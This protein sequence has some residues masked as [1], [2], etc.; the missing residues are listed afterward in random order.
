MAPHTRRSPPSPV[1]RPSPRSRC[2]GRPPA[3]EAS[4]SRSRR[5]GSP[6]AC[7][8]PDTRGSR[9]GRR[10]PH[11][12]REA[13]GTAAGR[14]VGLD[15]VGPLELDGRRHGVDPGQVLD[16]RVALEPSRQLGAPVAGDPGDHHTAPGRHL[17][18]GFRLRPCPDGGL[19]ASSRRSRASSRPVTS[20]LA[21]CPRR[22]SSSRAPWPRR[23]ELVPRLRPRRA[24]SSSSWVARSPRSAAEPARARLPACDRVPS[25]AARSASATPFSL[26]GPAPSALCWPGSG[27][28]TR[29]RRAAPASGTQAAAEAPPARR[30]DRRGDPRPT[31]ACWTASAGA[32]RAA[33]A[34]RPPGC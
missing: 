12:F 16:R 34:R 10:C 21:S 31:R 13:A 2:A 7:P 1:P 32:A 9:S 4:R 25:I 15:E 8:A 5:G 20:S 27:T 6:R 29:S 11:R 19:E 24:T 26:A 30:P 18:L 33:R 14:D 28:E 22:A 23:A 17:I 3:I